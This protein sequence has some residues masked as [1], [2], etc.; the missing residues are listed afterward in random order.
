M[1]SPAPISAR[2]TVDAMTLVNPSSGIAND[3]LNLF[4]EITMLIE[5]LPNM[6]ELSED[7]FAW[8]PVSYEDYF[9]RSTLA[10]RESALEAFRN[11]DTEFRRTFETCVEELDNRATGAI[12][13]IRL[14]LR[15][16]GN[17]APQT[18][19]WICERHGAHLR[20]ALERV[21]NVVNHG[22]AESVENAQARAD[23]LL[24]VRLAA[25][26][27]L[28]EFHNTPRFVSEED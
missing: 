20:E 4:N 21:V 12:A 22:A 7:V 15:Q 13:A 10:G 25:I 18:L 17:S 26:K 28:E 27:R 9:A 19:R 6:P 11:L 24:A 2:I 8:R 14:H 1:G 3:Y 16:R 23:R 5:Q